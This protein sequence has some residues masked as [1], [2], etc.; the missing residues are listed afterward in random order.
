MHLSLIQRV[1]LGF[2]ILTI[3][4][5]TIAGSAFY[6]QIRMAQQL[7]LTANTLTGLLDRA[8]TT[9]S[10]LQNANRA[11]MQHANTESEDERSRLRGVFDESQSRFSSTS[12]TL[13]TELAVFPSILQ[14]LAGT[15]DTASRLLLLANNHL[16]IQDQRITS[17]QQSF[18]ELNNF[19]GEFIFF[20]DDFN[21]LIDAANRQDLQ[22]TVWDL[23][24]IVNQSNSAKIYL[25]KVLSLSES[26]QIE[27]AKTELYGYADRVKEKATNIENSTPDLYADVEFYVEVLN[28]AIREQDGVFQRHLTF[29]D[30]NKTSN[31]MLSE[32]ASLMDDMSSSL[33]NSVAQIRNT[34]SDARLTAEQ[35]F[36]SSVTLNVA[37]SGISILIAVIVGFTVTRSIKVPLSAITKALSQLSKGDLSHTIDAKFHSEMGLVAKNINLL[38]KQLSQL[39]SEIQQSANT[40][41]TVAEASL[42]MSEQTNINVAEQRAHTDSVATAVTEMEAAIHEVASHAS[43]ASDEVSKVTDQAQSNMDNM[44]KNLRFVSRLKESLDTASEVIRDLSQES[45]QIGDILNV[46]QGIA[47]QTNLL[48]LNAA[49]EAA[50]AGEQGRGFAVVADEVRSLANRT[51]QSANEIRSMIESLQGKA[52]KAVSIVEGNL[53]HADRSVTQTQETS[54]S[55]EEMVNSLSNVNDMS[56]SIATASEQQ[57]AVAKEVAENVVQIS[58]MAENIASGAKTAAENSKSLNDLSNQQTELVSRF[59]L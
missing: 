19:E 5:L 40:I 51:Q 47:E 11:M 59:Q 17:R 58:D 22:A 1:V 39:I 7:E 31:E 21:S 16:N 43:A 56:R 30:L 24:F 14:S 13:T 2:L 54:H 4:L 36:K 23:E 37:L 33:S 27:Q 8:T 38:S 34:S 50:R 53:E 55:L 15:A 25:Q 20:E 32:I 18:I 28:R 52:E 10:H 35:T 12:E 42:N 9:L 46:I 26:E 3:L 45:Q 49:I 29:V 48:A 44:G 57:S 41:S 6:S